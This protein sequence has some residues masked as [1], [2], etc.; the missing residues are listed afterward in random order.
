MVVCVGSCARSGADDKDCIEVV[1]KEAAV[2]ALMM[3]LRLTEGIDYSL[4]NQ[5][6]LPSWE[7]ITDPFAVK[8]LINEDYLWRKQHRI[9]ATAKGRQRLNAVLQKMLL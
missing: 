4:W 2:E 5:K 9:G 8:L 6:G 7:A 1:D 3:G